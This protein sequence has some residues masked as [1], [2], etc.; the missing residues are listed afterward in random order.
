[1]LHSLN[2]TKTAIKFIRSVKQ[3]VTQDGETFYTAKVGEPADKAVAKELYEKGFYF[4]GRDGNEGVV[5][6]LETDKAARRRG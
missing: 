3:K 1:M 5:W 6:S 2:N 4:L